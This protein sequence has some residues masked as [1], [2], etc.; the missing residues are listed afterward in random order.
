MN[1]EEEAPARVSLRQVRKCISP[2]NNEHTPITPPINAKASKNNVDGFPPK[3]IP[4]K[5]SHFRESIAIELNG[6]QAK[7]KEKKLT[8]MILFP[9]NV[10]V[11]RPSSKSK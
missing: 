11:Q 5:K 8:R 4:Q 2:A 9:I 10:F 6:N 1:A 3:S 7:G